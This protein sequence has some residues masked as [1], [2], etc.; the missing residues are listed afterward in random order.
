MHAW[1][2][3]AVRATSRARTR[4]RRLADIRDAGTPALRARLDP[5]CSF[6]GGRR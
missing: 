3:T 2:A 6:A 4:H 5:P 1:A